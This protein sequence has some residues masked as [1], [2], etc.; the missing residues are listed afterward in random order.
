MQSVSS[1]QSRNRASG[2]PVSSKV[3][4]AAGL[5][6]VVIIFLFTLLPPLSIPLG[7]IRLSPYRILLLIML[8]PCFFK[9]ISGKAGKIIA[10]DV[11]IFLHAFW[12]VIAL[13]AVHGP[14]RE[15]E[16]AGIYVIEFLGSYLLA[17]CYIRSSHQF[18]ELV[19]WFSFILL[20]LLPLAIFESLTGRHPVQQLFNVYIIPVEPRMG[21]H[22]AMATFEHP[23]LYGVFAASTF[24]LSYYLT[25][26]KSSLTKTAMRTAPSLFGTFFSLSSGPLLSLI[27][28]FG[29]IGWEFITRRIPFRWLILFLFFV[30]MYITIDLLSNRKPIHVFV[31]YMTF[32]VQS[33][34]TRITIWD[35]GI[36]E[37]IRNPWFGIGMNDWIRPFW[38]SRSVDNYWLVVMMRFGYPAIIFYALAVY[39]MIRAFSK[40][41]LRSKKLITIRKAWTITIMTLIFAVCTVHLW[42]ATFCHFL[43]L[44]GSCVWL[45]DEKEEE[46]L[47]KQ[48]QPV[49]R[50]MHPRHL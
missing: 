8:V 39:T 43:F 24:T 42:N 30:L 14:F 15:I 41:R 26:Y 35:Y 20:L 13:S 19:K 40:R 29:M 6:I 17:R 46:E 9:F 50:Q 34:Y 48:S 45:L 2:I 22:R 27:L 31:T 25:I 49:N 36:A 12:A 18:E 16:A 33:A 38:L 5:S 1:A 28:Q 37:V 3:G 23:I 7:P 10:A 21:L 4:K 11:F 47:K 44:L 32:N